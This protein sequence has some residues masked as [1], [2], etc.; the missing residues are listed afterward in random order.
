MKVDLN[1]LE[2]VAEIVGL[3]EDDV[4]TGYS[5]RGMYGKTCVGFDLDGSSALLA[6]GAALAAVFPNEYEDFIHRART[7]GMGRGIIVY[8]PGIETDAVESDEDEEE[9]EDE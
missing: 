3:D 6:L 8:F 9:D 5:G 2:E 4:R 1:A 7:D